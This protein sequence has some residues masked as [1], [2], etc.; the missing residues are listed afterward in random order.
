MRIRPLTGLG[1]AWATP[2]TLGSLVLFLL[3]LWALR[4]ARPA[5]WRD[6]AWE[7]SI[8]PGSRFWRWYSRDGGWAG[9]TLGF[10]I[11]FSPGAADEPS[12]ALHERRHVFQN[13]MLGPLFMPLYALLWVACGYRAHPFERDAC[14]AETDVP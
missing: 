14:Q 1:Y 3:P 4:Q 2:T 11:L 12:T 7:W 13:L 5:R 9:T 8:R 6:G 10:C